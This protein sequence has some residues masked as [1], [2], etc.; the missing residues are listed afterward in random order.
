MKGSRSKKSA[1]RPNKVP[2]KPNT[3]RKRT[4]TV[5][6]PDVAGRMDVEPPADV[7]VNVGVVKNGWLGMDV[8]EPSNAAERMNE[9]APPT[10]VPPKY[11]LPA[12][13]LPEGYIAPEISGA[14]S[15]HGTSLNTYF[16]LPP[17]I[18]VVI[19]TRRGQV[20]IDFVIE[21]LLK[22]I[23]KNLHTI[24]KRSLQE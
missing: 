16:R 18:E 7:P 5:C 1:Q 17:H 11:V 15:I 4:I 23:D 3:R 6:Q 9:E 22:W 12:T 13:P 10:I 19:F 21:K 20:S 14:L 24:S 8:E 2:A